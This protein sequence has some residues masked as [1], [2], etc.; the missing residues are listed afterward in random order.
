MTADPDA[1]GSLADRTARTTPPAL[2]LSERTVDD[3]ILSLSFPTRRDF[4]AADGTHWCVH[5]RDAAAMAHARGA[6]CLVFETGNVLRV[7]WHYPR[8]WRT[9]SDAELETL[10][11]GR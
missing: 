7:V 9:L 2:V 6:R 8:D 3:V 5:E 1:I 4:V 11:R 10:S